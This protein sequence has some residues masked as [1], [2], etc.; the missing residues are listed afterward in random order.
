MKRVRRIFVRVLLVLAILVAG[1][2]GVVQFRKNRTFAAAE[3]GLK[4]TKDP[5]VIARGRYLALGPAHCFGCHSRP[6]DE[7]AAL[8]GDEVA[9]AGGHVFDIPPG[10]LFAPNIT[11]DP[12][13]G[14]GR[15][16]DAELARI[17]RLGIRADGRVA[18]PLMPF[19]NLAD[20]DLVA[21]LSYL[22]SLKPVKNAVPD[23]EWHLLGDFLRAFVLK[24]EGPAGTPPARMV[25]SV[26]AEYG[27]YLA[28]SVANCNGCHTDR[29]F[30]SGAFIGKPFAGGSPMPAL[31]DPKFE[32]AAPNITAD[33]KT[34]R[35][36]KFTEDEFVKRLKSGTPSAP[37]THMP[38]GSFRHMTDEDLRAVYR[39][40]K[41]VPPVEN[42]VGPLRRPIR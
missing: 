30:R 16:T 13:T 12:E 34:G 35:L 40:L 8:R 27:R 3:L 39:Y 17:M 31:D 10:K 29:D 5:K 2:F 1:V 26:T 36:A 37:G 19:Q 11:P 32:V 15:R 28:H 14:I 38:W 4:A 20:E 25:P 42:D 18:M 24:P 21:L 33:P 6:E 22:R 41:T 23:H 9:P 7:A